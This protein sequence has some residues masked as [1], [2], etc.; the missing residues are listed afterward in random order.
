MPA[1][2]IA[3]LLMISDYGLSRLGVSHTLE[4]YDMP[5]NAAEP[6]LWECLSALFY[7]RHSSSHRWHRAQTRPLRCLHHLGDG[8]PARAPSLSDT[9]FS[10]DRMQSHSSFRISR[11]R[12][13][14]F[15]ANRNHR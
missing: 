14:F 3:A 13:N 2:V 11:D 1:N 8:A 5:L 6:Y 7:V 12:Y 15:F 10:N 4:L 9:G